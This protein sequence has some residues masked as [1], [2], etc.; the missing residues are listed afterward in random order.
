MDSEVAELEGANPEIP[1]GQEPEPRRAQKPKPPPR[2][3]NPKVRLALIGATVV[4]LLIV[5]FVY[6]HY[7]NRVSTDDAQVDGH[8]FPMSPRISGTVTEVL[9]HDNEMVKAGQVLV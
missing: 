9:V 1:V 7:H 8:L 3:T 2:L 6:L 5:M 4:L